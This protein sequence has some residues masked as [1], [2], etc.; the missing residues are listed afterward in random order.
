MDQGGW[1]DLIHNWQNVF[2]TIL[3]TIFCI[4]V[5]LVVVIKFPQKEKLGYLFFLYIISA[6]LLF[7][8]CYFLGTAVLNLAGRQSSVL[9]ETANICFAFFEYFVFHNFFNNI[10]KSKVAKKI[11][12]FFLLAYI[13]VIILLI[14]KEFDYTISRSEIQHYNDIAISAELLFL[15]TLCIIYYYELVK[16]KPIINLLKSPSFWI[17]SGLFF[18]CILITTFFLIAENL[19]MHNRQIFYVFYAVHFISFGL[20]FLA[21]SKAFLCKRPLT[22]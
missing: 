9:F 18:Y 21:I 20:L 7:A 6:L 1:E 4:L 13:P 16:A 11:M 17:V 19:F 2:Y 3:F 14:I 10:L 5:A 12:H 8:I 15:A 22:T